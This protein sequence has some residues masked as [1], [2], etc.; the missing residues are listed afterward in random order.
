MYVIRIGKLWYSG[1][2]TSDTN[3]VSEAVVSTTYGWNTAYI[4][5]KFSKAEYMAEKIGGTVMY[6]PKP[7]MATGDENGKDIEQ[8]DD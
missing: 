8:P 6:L 7:K 3:L 5:R 4:F 1:F 2:K